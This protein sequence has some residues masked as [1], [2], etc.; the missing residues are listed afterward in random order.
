M[1]YAVEVLPMQSCTHAQTAHTCSRMHLIVFEL[2]LCQKMVVGIVKMINS[3]VHSQ[4][5]Y[6]I[7]LNQLAR[8]VIGK[9]YQ[10]YNVNLTSQQLNHNNSSQNYYQSTGLINLKCYQPKAKV[11]RFWHAGGYIVPTCRLKAGSCCFG[12][13][14]FKTYKPSWF[15]KSFECCYC[16]SIAKFVSLHQAW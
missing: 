12:L 11:A 16:Y 13:V 2:A 15:S 14:T 9:S 7:L 10:T 1:K 5:V 6:L 4:E 3:T 8:Q